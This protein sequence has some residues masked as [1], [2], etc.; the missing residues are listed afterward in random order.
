[1]DGDV[2][3]VAERLGSLPAG[4]ELVTLVESLDPAGLSGEEQ[5]ALLTAEHRLATWF[6]ER[7][8]RSAAALEA[9]RS[10]GAEAGQSPT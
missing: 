2:V 10:A 7:A 4:S 3:S 5:V 8:K 1:M 9:S 6:A